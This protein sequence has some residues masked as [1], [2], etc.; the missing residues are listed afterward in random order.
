M[1]DQETI[2]IT[3]DLEKAKQNHLNE[4]FLASFGANIQSMLRVMMGQS[5]FP[6]PFR[7]VGKSNDLKALANV[8]GREKR[9]M[10]SYI[11]HGLNDPKVLS[12]R[13]QLERA[14]RSFER[15]T[16]IKWPLK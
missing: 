15:E 3:I 2:S 10:E 6:S 1:I 8:L 13:Y 5:A 4:S 14:V 7:V 9:Y 11:K 12:S 16:G